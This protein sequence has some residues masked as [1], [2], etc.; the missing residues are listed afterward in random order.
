MKFYCITV[1]CHDNSYFDNMTFDIRKWFYK[2][3]EHAKKELEM[4][5]SEAC[6]E[7]FGGEPLSFLVDVIK[8]SNKIYYKYKDDDG[9]EFGVYIEELIFQN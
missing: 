6:K 7:Y 3:K 9:L 8:K 1:Y 5:F 4:R 2:N